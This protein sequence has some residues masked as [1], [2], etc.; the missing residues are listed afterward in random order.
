MPYI[1]VFFKSSSSFKMHFEYLP[2]FKFSREAHC[3]KVYLVSANPQYT[4]MF[5]SIPCLK[6]ERKQ[7]TNH[8]YD[9]VDVGMIILI[10]N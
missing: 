4:P 6:V 2:F 10:K 1:K 7:D 3:F 8:L 5:K 9:N